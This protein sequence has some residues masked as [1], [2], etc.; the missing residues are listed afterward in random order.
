M[1]AA[2]ESPYKSLPPSL[3]DHCGSSRTD[4]RAPSHTNSPDESSSHANHCGSSDTL[5]LRGRLRGGDT[6]K[7]NEVVDEEEE[8]MSPFRCEITAALRTQITAHPPIQTTAPPCTHTQHYCL[9]Q[10]HMEPR[11]RQDAGTRRAAGADDIV[12]LREY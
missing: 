7:T 5:E 6:A 4:H 3:T 10:A 8:Y 12:P 1:E 11:V 2:D 9:S